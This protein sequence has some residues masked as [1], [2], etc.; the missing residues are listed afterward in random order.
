[1]NG[2]PLAW[3]SAERRRRGRRCRFALRAKGGCR[4]AG[5][6]LEGSRIWFG[7]HTEN[8]LMT[9]TRHSHSPIGTKREVDS[10]AS[11]SIPLCRPERW[12]VSRESERGS[13]HT[14]RSVRRVR[15]RNERGTK[16]TAS[17]VLGCRSVGHRLLLKPTGGS[18]AGGVIYLP[19]KE[20]S[21]PVSTGCSNSRIDGS[22][23]GWGFVLKIENAATSS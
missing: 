20:A 12:R 5:F 8:F 23:W 15:E 2:R 19:L 21:C 18:I 17:A 13:P 9:P 3:P 11:G 14:R 4:R 6:P 22:R 16:Q 7:D 10:G 1:M